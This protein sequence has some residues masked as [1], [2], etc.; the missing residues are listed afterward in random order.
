VDGADPIGGHPFCWSAQR[1]CRLMTTGASLRPRDGQNRSS[2]F[3]QRDVD[4]YPTPLRR[5]DRHRVKSGRLYRRRRI[6]TLSCLILAAGTVWLAVSLGGALANPT[7]GSSFGARL[8]EWARQHGAAA[9]VN[10]AENEWYSHHAPPVGGVPPKGSFRRPP[11]TSPAVTDGTAPSP[12][13]SRRYCP[14]PAPL[15]SGE[16]QWSPVGRLVG[17]PTRRL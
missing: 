15:I 13:T 12:T 17:R 9:E 3:G 2:E 1:E 4:P 16:G 8:A 5:P 10:W 11:S 14:W 7:L 6:R